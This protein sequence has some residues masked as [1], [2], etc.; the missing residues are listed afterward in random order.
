MCGDYEFLCKLYGISGAQGVHCCLWCN[1]TKS[2]IQ[3]EYTGYDS[4]DIRTLADMKEL[5]Q[6]YSIEGKNEKKNASKFENVINLPLIDISL[7]HVCPP[8]LHILLGITKRHHVLMENDCYIIDKLIAVQ[9]AKSNSHL[10]DSLFHKYV[11]ERRA[12]LDMKKK[13]AELAN[14][15]EQ[16]EDNVPLAQLEKTKHSLEHQIKQMDNK[17]KL[18]RKKSNLN[19]LCGPISSYL[20]TVLQEHNIHVQAYHGRSFVGNH[21]HKYFKPEV[22]QALSNGIEEKAKTISGALHVNNAACKVAEKY[23][24]L[25]ALFSK[26]HISISHGNPIDNISINE[27]HQHIMEYMDFF[28]THFPSKVIPKM[29]FLEAHVITWM[30]RWNH[31]MAFHGEQAVESIHAVFNRLLR[32]SSGIRS[33][34]KQL[35]S[36]M[37]NHHLKN[38]PELIQHIPRP[39]KRKTSNE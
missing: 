3:D 21:C 7:K 36:I 9:I 27:C 33:R 34:S 25:N 29:H 38:D 20:D 31:G 5:Y 4:Y 18:A 16:I 8:Y 26:V 28:R 1:I 2:H 10:S 32:A 30:R 37:R 6:S 39:Q 35:A 23:V 13:R 19:K 11:A 17:M 14:D 15:L 24:K 12:I 22:Y